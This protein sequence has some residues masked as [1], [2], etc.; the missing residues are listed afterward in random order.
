MG[1]LPQVLALHGFSG[2]GADFE[3]LRAAS[4][5]LVWHTPDLPGHGAN[6]STDPRD[7]RLD[8]IAARLV[9][10]LTAL[11]RPR[12]LLGYSMGGRVALLTA[13]RAPEEIDGLVLIGASPGLTEAADRK[14]RRELDY[15]RSLRVFEIGAQAFAEE[16][17]RLPIIATQQRIPEPWRTQ[18]LRRRADNDDRGLAWSLDI[19]GTGRMAPLHEQLG[20]L[21]TPALLVVG[22]TDDK[23]RR[24]AEQMQLPQ[25]QLCVL[26]D[27]GHAAHLEQPDAFMSVLRRWCA[28]VPGVC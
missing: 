18:M 9:R 14:A 27:A 24:I 19:T 4:T 11:P 6:L 28:D 13:L 1:A 12:V 3:L 8:D 22:E 16:W 17:S 21:A 15:Q 5:D 25:S 7:Y 20:G 26:P 23:F 10:T 2:A